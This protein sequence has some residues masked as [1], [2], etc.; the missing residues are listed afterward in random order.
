M[1]GACSKAH[2]LSNNKSCHKARQSTASH[3]RSVNTTHWSRGPYDVGAAPDVLCWTT[4]NERHDKGRQTRRDHICFTQTAD[5]NGSS[6]CSHANTFHHMAHTIH[7]MQTQIKNNPQPAP[8]LQHPLQ[9]HAHL[10]A[11]LVDVCQALGPR[12]GVQHGH[13]DGQATHLAHLV[14]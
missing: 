1:G 13:Q 5:T 7:N 9:R 10:H 4:T 11:Q 8:T 12:Q 6:T 2:S 14:L 3:D